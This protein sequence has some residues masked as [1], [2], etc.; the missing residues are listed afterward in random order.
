MVR[1]PSGWHEHVDCSNKWLWLVPLPVDSVQTVPSIGIF[2]RKTVIKH[3]VPSN[4]F[5]STKPLNYFQDV[6]VSKY[7]CHLTENSF[8]TFD[9]E[10]PLI[11]SYMYNQLQKC[12]DIPTKNKLSSF[13]SLLVARLWDTCIILTSLLPLMQSC[14]SKFWACIVVYC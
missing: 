14:S 11:W 13:K 4:V 9:P 5:W 3:V 2:E 8:N 1:P 6:R 10:M 7:I 12:W